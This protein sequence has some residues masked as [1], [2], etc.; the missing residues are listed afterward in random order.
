MKH[1][2]HKPS[3]LVPCE[4][5]DPQSNE[6]TFYYADLIEPVLALWTPADINNVGLPKDP[7]WKKPKDWV[8][9]YQQTAGYACMHMPVWARFLK[10]NPEIAGL[11]KTLADDW[12]E[13]CIYPNASLET[14]NKYEKLLKKYG[15]TCNRSHPELQEGFYPID[16]ECL[17]MVTSERFPKD[18][19]SLV[20]SNKNDRWASV[21]GPRYGLAIMTEN[22]D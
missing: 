22:C 13:C 16:I 6:Q 18:L 8:K 20:S 1:R 9:F 10:P 17:A 5:L 19:K 12:F 3:P 2:P 4:W 14:V 21:W 11:M 7:N 15:L